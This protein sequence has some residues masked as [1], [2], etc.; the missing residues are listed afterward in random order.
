MLER[1]VWWLGLLALGIALAACDGDPDAPAPTPIPAPTVTP[2]ATPTAIATPTAVPTLTATPSPSPTP[3]SAVTPSPS[4][5]PAPTA[6]PM[7]MRYGAPDP[8][9]AV[10]APGEYAFFSVDGDAIATYEGLRRDAVRLVIHERDADGRSWAAFYGAVDAGDHFEW[11]EADD[12]W[13]RYFVDGALPPDAPHRA[14]AVRRYGYAY[15]GCSGPTAATGDRLWTWNPPNMRSPFNVPVRHGPWLL[16]PN[17][18]WASPVLEEEVQVRALPQD[19]ASGDGGTEW[20][21]QPFPEPRL[22]EGWTGGVGIAPHGYLEGYYFYADDEGYLGLATTILLR[23]YLPAHEPTG[24]GT[25]SEAYV[26]EIRIVDGRPA[27]LWYLAEP[28]A[29]TSTRVSIYDDATGIEYITGGYATHLRN[30]IEAT[31]EIARTL[32]PDAL[33]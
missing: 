30:D 9:G 5:T 21:Q 29:I 20:P 25:G 3:V 13:V 19:R 23:Y 7:I 16:V 26:H 6:T 31:L 28:R 33:R 8:D 17:G 32:V 11:R 12:C 10:D 22:P 4:P 24:E 2:T 27:L 1:A 14:F 15:T 18:M